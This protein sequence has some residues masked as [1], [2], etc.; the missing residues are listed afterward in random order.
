M[1][2]AL[3]LLLVVGSIQSIDAQLSIGLKTNYSVTTSPSSQVE[4]STLS[5]PIELLNMEYVSSKDQVSYGLSLY[6]ENALLFMNM[7]IMYA[8]SEHQ[9]KVVNLI[10]DF[11]RSNTTKTFSHKKSNISVPLAAGLK[12][13]NIKIGGGPI[14]NYTLSSSNDLTSID[15]LVER[16]NKI[17]MGF[18]FL[19]G[20]II[21]DRIHIDLRREINF[22]DVGDN[23]SY[24]G[25]PVD[26][27]SSPHNVSLSLS[28]FL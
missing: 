22:S 23:Y 21:Q 12:L 28:I 10:D 17:N 6:D 13:N 26:L 20:Y 25:V 15:N 3:I 8:Q 27:G 9:Y 14:F 24:Q 16:E 1:K 5:Q 18:Q 4:L 7:D 11:R 19:I 2:N